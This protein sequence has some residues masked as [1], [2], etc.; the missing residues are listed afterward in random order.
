MLS[1]TPACACVVMACRSLR[2]VPFSL[3]SYRHLVTPW[4]ARCAPHGPTELLP[5]QPVPVLLVLRDLRRRRFLQVLD[6]RHD[7]EGAGHTL[8]R[9]AEPPL[10]GL[11]ALLREHVIEHDLSSVRV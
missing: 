4:G 2:S 3:K 11:L 9:G 10:D 7:V 8:Q 1:E 5:E 6:A